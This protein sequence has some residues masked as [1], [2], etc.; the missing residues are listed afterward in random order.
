MAGPKSPRVL[1][2]PATAFLKPARARRRQC[3]LNSPAPSEPLRDPLRSDVLPPGPPLDCLSLA[4]P[5]DVLVAGG[6]LGLLL[7]RF[8][9]AVLGLVWAIVI[10]SPDRHSRWRMSHVFKEGVDAIPPAANRDPPA[11]VPPER[12]VLGV[13]APPV[14]ST[15]AGV[16]AHVR[17]AVKLV[18]HSQAAFARCVQAK[19]PMQLLAQIRNP[20]YNPID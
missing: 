14:H 10:D 13:I 5:G 7:R 2:T 11:A 19:L 4:L 8:P 1:N 6:V 17:K 20:R 9:S 16:E 15:P 12:T 3:T 18:V